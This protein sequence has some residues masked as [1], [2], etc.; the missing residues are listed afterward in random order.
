MSVLSVSQ[1]KTCSLFSDEGSPFIGLYIIRKET[2][3]KQNQSLG[4]RAQ[5]PCKKGVFALSKL[6]IFYRELLVCVD[7]MYFYFY[8]FFAK[9]T[10]ITQM[11]DNLASVVLLRY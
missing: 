6:R 4:G 9:Q 10:N 3:N 7:V 11:I 1:F 5:V 2:A 8:Y